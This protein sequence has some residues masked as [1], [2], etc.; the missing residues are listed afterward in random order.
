LRIGTEITCLE[1]VDSTN[2]YIRKNIKSLKNGSVVWAFSQTEGKGRLHRNW[3]SDP[4]GNIYFSF[5]MKDRKWLK[6]LTE[7]PIIVSVV[8]LRSV[9]ALFDDPKVNDL[10]LKWP[11][12]LLWKGAKL[13]GILME[14]DGDNLICGIGLNVEKAPQIE[15][16]N[17]ACVKDFLG[18]SK[19]IKQADFIGD[20]C[21]NFN[22]AMNQYLKTGFADFK[23]EWEQNCG[24]INK[25][26]A[27][28]EGL[29]DNTP[30]LGALFLGLNSD[31]G[32]IV[33]VDGES[34]KR[35]VYSGE[36]NV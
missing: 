36:L 7:F 11:N 15:G 12:D 35:V 2:K 20:F 13:S 25:K 8:L 18:D 1:T 32:A 17:I 23:S 19:T 9:K 33:V 10:K 4:N 29:E 31:G 21:K 28:S 27:L 26:V 30:K 14:I 5:L 6:Q 3:V 24:H 34:E 16:K 22:M